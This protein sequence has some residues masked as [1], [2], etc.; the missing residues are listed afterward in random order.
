MGNRLFQ[1]MEGQQLTGSI[2]VME[3]TPWLL[4]GALAEE[5]PEIDYTVVATRYKSRFRI[6]RV[7]GVTTQPAVAGMPPM[8]EDRARQSAHGVAPVPH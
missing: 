1:V 2:L 4:S 6:G 7:R 5:M 3:S 8:S